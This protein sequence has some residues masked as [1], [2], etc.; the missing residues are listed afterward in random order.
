MQPSPSNVVMCYIFSHKWSPSK[1][2]K[3]NALQ[4]VLPF[5]LRPHHLQGT[6]QMEVTD[7]PYSY[8]V[9]LVSHISYAL[10]LKILQ[11]LTSSGP[12]LNMIIHLVCF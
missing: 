5:Q 9:L 2:L 10:S 6:Q 8:V 1:L 7:F 3:L 4:Q 12:E 11:W